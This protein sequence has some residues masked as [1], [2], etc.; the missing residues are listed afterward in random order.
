[1]ND[2]FISEVTAKLHKTIKLS[3][4]S[5]MSMYDILSCREKT[6][7]VSECVEVRHPTRHFIGYF[8][9]DFYRPER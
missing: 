6:K 1:M 7:S 5:A 9:D 4:S 8:R 3:V 2:T